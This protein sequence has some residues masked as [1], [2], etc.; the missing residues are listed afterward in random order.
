MLDLNIQ[1]R[2]I[3]ENEALTFFAQNLISKSKRKFKGPRG[4][5]Y[6]LHILNTNHL[7]ALTQE[8]KRG[9]TIAQWI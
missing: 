2:Q 4:K 5:F 6:G 1:Q 3:F 8:L 7:Y 9:A